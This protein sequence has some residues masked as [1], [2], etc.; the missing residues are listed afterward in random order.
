[1]L[2]GEQDF[3]QMH[4]AKIEEAMEQH[5]LDFM[6][7]ST[8]YLSIQALTQLVVSL[9]MRRKNIFNTQFLIYLGFLLI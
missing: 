8:L 9:M 4:Q 5:S 7:S 2:N 1:M 6:L 3:S